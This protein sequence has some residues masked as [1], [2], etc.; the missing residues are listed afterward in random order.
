VGPSSGLDLAVHLVMIVVLA[1]GLT[2]A[3]RSRSPAENTATD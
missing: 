3:T 1:I 2:V